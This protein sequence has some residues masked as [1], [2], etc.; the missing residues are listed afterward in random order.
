M[1]KALS[2]LETVVT[3]IGIRVHDRRAGGRTEKKKK[4]QTLR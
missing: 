2:L 4:K 1:K 3:T